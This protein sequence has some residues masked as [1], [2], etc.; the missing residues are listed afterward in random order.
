M[1]R[2]VLI[3]ILLL[4]G[5]SLWGQDY[6]H[7]DYYGQGN[8]SQEAFL[9][10]MSQI[11]KAVTFEKP[12]LLETYRADIERATV[13][14]MQNGKILFHL[15]GTALDAIFQSRQTR[16]ADILR[17]GRKAEND[18]QRKTYYTWAWYYLCSLPEG[19]QLPG[20]NEIRQWLLDHV[21]LSSAP[22]PVPMTH[23]EREVSAIRDIIGEVY[24]AP[25]EVAVPETRPAQPTQEAL[26]PER[27]KVSAIDAAMQQGELVNSFKESL[28]GPASVEPATPRSTPIKTSI[29]LTGSF[30]PEFVPGIFVNVRKKWGVVVGAQSNFVGVK[31][32]YA[33]LSNGSRPDGE[34]YIWPGGASKIAHFSVTGGA[35]YSFTNYLSAY[36]AAGYGYRNIYWDDA[37]G[38]WARIEDLSARG[39]AVS[40]GALFGW[41]YLGVSLGLSTIAFRTLGVTLG[42]GVHF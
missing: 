24:A 11:S 15:R 32:S 6:I 36:L 23:I 29:L 42:L 8:T 31:E 28:D 30:A 16:A 40:G 33:A 4:L 26:P 39:V 18:A 19:H 41:K 35:S 1:R 21:E 12:A 22:L 3:W 38:Q 7:R 34:G 37:D 25:L 2:F 10:L 17:E 5:F 14:Q 9:A 20:K 13:E 27:E